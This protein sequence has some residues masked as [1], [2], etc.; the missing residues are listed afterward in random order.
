VGCAVSQVCHLPGGAKEDT[1]LYALGEMASAIKRSPKNE[2]SG[3]YFR[4]AKYGRRLAKDQR[5]T[6]ADLGFKCERDVA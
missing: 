6:W 4:K 3:D 1:Y 5:R 2:I